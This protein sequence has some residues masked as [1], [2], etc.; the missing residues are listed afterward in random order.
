MRSSAAASLLVFVLAM[1]PDEDVVQRR[2][3]DPPLK[4]TVT[5]I[6]DAG[7]TVRSN[8]GAM[9]VVPWDRVRHVQTEQTHDEL[10]EYMK[11]A[12]DLWRARSRV[13][14]HDTILAESLLARL[15]EQYRGQKHET[16]LVV[17]E[18]LLRCRTA[19]SD[20][21]MAVIPALEV[22]RLRRAGITTEAYSTLDPVLDSEYSL[23]TVLAPVWLESPRLDSLGH[24]L[25]AY[26][27]K[28]DEVVQALAD[29]YRQA[30]R[31]T[32]GRPLEPAGTAPD[33]PGVVLLGRLNACSSE[34]PDRRSAAREQ[35]RRAIPSMPA[36]AEA[37]SRY[38]I[39]VSLL[40]ETGIGRR[41]TGA[42]SLVHL[43]ARFS[44]TQHFLAGLALAELART[45]QHRGDEGAA[46]RLR[47]ELRRTYPNH[48]LHA[49]VE[50]DSP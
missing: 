7:V 9:H 6:D 26:D 47:S 40:A 46:A 24:D 16:A 10:S 36:W 23:C 41:Q 38:K 28:G 27:A 30:V 15:F 21:V 50:A 17:A 2:S 42:V 43:P 31:Q 4:G 5:L 44:R 12:V 49:S 1:A 19:R 20:Q 32:L 29:A 3:A 22:A 13:E 18:G 48:P 14:R 45:M 8:L 37:W 39:G 35:L 11:I 34:S 25:D 33:H